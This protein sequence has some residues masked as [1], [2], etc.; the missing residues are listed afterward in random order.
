MGALARELGE[1]LAISPT[2]ATLVGTLREPDPARNGDAL[3]SLFKVTGG[4]VRP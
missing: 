2:S 4:T 1:E 3:Y